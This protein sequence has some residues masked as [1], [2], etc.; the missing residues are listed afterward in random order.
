MARLGTE[1]ARVHFPDPAVQ[2]A[3][4]FILDNPKRTISFAP[5]VAQPTHPSPK[6]RWRQFYPIVLSL[7]A[8]T[9]R[10]ARTSI[11][12]R[13]NVAI[14]QGKLENRRLH[15][16]LIRQSERRVIGKREPTTLALPSDDPGV[17]HMDVAV[18][19]ALK[20]ATAYA[21]P[22]EARA[23]VTSLTMRTVEH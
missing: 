23:S 12:G 13:T 11:G 6:I 22:H 7:R 15:K 10:I 17:D 2:R 21:V 3:V 1:L 20:L 4:E 16:S 9:N 19:D 5:Q 18:I 14:A 8:I